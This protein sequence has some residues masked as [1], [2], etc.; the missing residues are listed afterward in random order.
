MTATQTA[1]RAAEPVSNAVYDRGAGLLRAVYRRRLAT[2][3]LLSAPDFFLSAPRF[4]GAWRALRAEALAIARRLG[5]VPRFHEIMP[6]QADISNNDGRDWRLF[7]AKAYGVEAS[8]NLSLC[9]ELV[10]LLD[11]APEVLSASFSYLAPGKHVP[12]HR[13]PF[14]GVL[15]FHL[16]LDTPRDAHGRPAA[17]LEIDGI[18]H[19]MGD[20]DWLLWDDTFPHAVWN[21]GDTV[22]TVLL[23]DVWRPSMPA[24]LRL[25]SRTVVRAVQF[26]IRWR[27]LAGPDGGRS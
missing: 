13:G 8:P 5:S 1:E 16:T 21:E 11:A 24:D 23:L 2:P 7:I 3:A 9:P 18:E 26:G 20:G 15:R 6:E 4:I 22:R 10:S 12:R 14:G 27:G 17:V 19:R 25:L